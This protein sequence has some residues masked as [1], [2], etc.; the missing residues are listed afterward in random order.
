MFSDDSYVMFRDHRPAGDHHYLVIPRRHVT[1]VK[2]L[3]ADDIPV[4]REM[5]GIAKRV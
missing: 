4:V 3:T 2:S 5:E 1:G